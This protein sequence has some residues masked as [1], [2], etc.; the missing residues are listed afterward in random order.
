MVNVFECE[1]DELNDA[2]LFLQ[3]NDN[4][5]LQL[6]LNARKLVL[7]QY[8]VEKTETKLWDDIERIVKMY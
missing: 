8:T 4:I 1:V 3:K 6:A 5:R 2:I 7:D